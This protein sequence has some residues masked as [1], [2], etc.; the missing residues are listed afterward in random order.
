MNAEFLSLWVKFWAVIFWL[1]LPAMA[2]ILLKIIS[3]ERRYWKRR[4]QLKKDLHF[5]GMQS[6]REL[7]KS[8]LKELGIKFDDKFYEKN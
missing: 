6:T 1:S 2:F 3:M 8:R 4:N 7:Y 5:P